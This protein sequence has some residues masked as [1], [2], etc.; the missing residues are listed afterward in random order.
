MQAH[1]TFLAGAP[2]PEDF[3]CSL[4]FVF[5]FS[6]AAPRRGRSNFIAL[7]FQRTYFSRQ[8][9]DASATSVHTVRAATFDEI[10]AGRSIFLGLVR[11]SLIQGS[12][13]REG[14]GG[15]FSVKEGILKK[16]ILWGLSFARKFRREIIWMGDLCGVER[17]QGVW[18]NAKYQS[19]KRFWW[20][21]RER[22]NRIRLRIM[23]Y[24][25]VHI[26]LE[27][28]L[29]AS[30]EIC[31]SVGSLDSDQKDYPRLLYRLI[32]ITL[33]ILRFHEIIIERSKQ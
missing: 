17:H 5:S 4:G 23:K 22:D 18:Y 20:N 33:S 25:R 30:L 15:T 31:K 1:S 2:R 3:S 32:M 27:G 9:R 21:I 29:Q 26:T 13:S 24:K 14:E 10:F 8:L 11:E 28:C 6:P 19:R 12:R 7:P 16:L